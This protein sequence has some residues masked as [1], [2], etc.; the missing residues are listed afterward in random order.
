LPNG[1]RKTQWSLP[2]WSRWRSIA[3]LA[4]KGTFDTGWVRR[5][6][7]Y[8]PPVAYDDACTEVVPDVAERFEANDDPTQFTFHPRKWHKWSKGEPF[9]AEDLVFALNLMK[10]PAYGRD[11]FQAHR[12][13]AGG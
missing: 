8:Q 3:H 11:I 4:L 5:T 13:I 7:G 12:H 2:R 9:T 10:S 1:C 6:V